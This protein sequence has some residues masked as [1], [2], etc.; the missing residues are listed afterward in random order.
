MFRNI[1]FGLMHHRHKLLDAREIMNVY[2]TG[3]INVI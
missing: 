3:N 1:I 2:F